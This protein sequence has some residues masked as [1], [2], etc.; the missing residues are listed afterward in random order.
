MDPVAES[1]DHGCVLYTFSFLLSDPLTG[2]IIQPILVEVE[3]N[4]KLNGIVASCDCL[5]VPLYIVV[6]LHLF[7]VVD[8]VKDEQRD[9]YSHTSKEERVFLADHNLIL[10]KCAGD[11]NVDQ[12]GVS[13]ALLFVESFSSLVDVFSEVL[14][15]T[16]LLTHTLFHDL[17]LELISP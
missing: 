3:C 2:L 1:L 13:V 8:V 7:D 16:D 17:V 12:A 4:V 14:N 11:L 6:L 9:K 15:L 10:C 5:N